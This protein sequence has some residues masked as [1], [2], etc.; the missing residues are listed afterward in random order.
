V[1]TEADRG[2]LSRTY[3]DSIRRALETL[4]RPHTQV[5]FVI[6]GFGDEDEDCDEL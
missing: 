6:A 1:L 4:G 5:R 3:L 2:H